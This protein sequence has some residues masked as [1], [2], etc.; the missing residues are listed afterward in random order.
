MVARTMTTDAEGDDVDSLT[1]CLSM[2]GEKTF[3]AGAG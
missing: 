3:G 1:G 2:H